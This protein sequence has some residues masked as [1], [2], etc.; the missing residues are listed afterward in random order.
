M[1]P[2]RVH[3]SACGEIES[4]A[5]IAEHN[6]RCAENGERT[7]RQPITLKRITF[8]ATFTRAEVAAMRAATTT[9]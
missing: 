7:Y 6:R 2:Q 8:T 4:L 3:C 5:A 1:S 9:P